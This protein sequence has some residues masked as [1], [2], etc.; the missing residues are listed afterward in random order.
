M[1]IVIC[2]CFLNLVQIQ[3]SSIAITKGKHIIPYLFVLF[4]AF[5]AVLFA[6]F[7]SVAAIAFAMIVVG[8]VLLIVGIVK[9]IVAPFGGLCLVGTGLVCAGIGI[10]F[11][12]LSI[13]VCKVVIPGA[14]RG[15]VNLC[16]MP[17]KKRRG[18]AV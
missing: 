4:V 5:A 16:R 18:E 14:V 17:F 2:T 15:I 6:L 8:V 10:L 1:D 12:I 3:P 7:I 11:A 13:G 9:L